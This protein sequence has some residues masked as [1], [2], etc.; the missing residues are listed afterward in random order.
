MNTNLAFTPIDDLR[1]QQEAAE[2]ARASLTHIHVGLNTTVRVTRDRPARERS[3][4]R[5]LAAYIHRERL[6][7]E[8]VCERL[9]ATVADVRAALT[10]SAADVK[11][12]VSRIESLRAILEANLR[13]PA[14]TAQCAA[15]IK[16]FKF[17]VKYGK[18]AEFVDLSR[19]GKTTIADWLH[20][21]HLDNAA[22]VDCP[23]EESYAAFIGSVARGCGITMSE[24]KKGRGPERILEQIEAMLGAGGLG[25]L[26]IDEGH[27][28][29]PTNIA[30]K[31]K[32]IEYDRKLWD[33]MKGR[34]SI[35]L[36]S[37]PQTILSSNQAQS[38]KNKRWNPA[39]WE[40]RV[41][42]FFP[43]EEVPEADVVKVA[44]WHCPEGSAAVIDPL[45]AFAR[46]TPGFYGAMVNV[47]DRA[48]FEAEI[49]GEKLGPKHVKVAMA[50]AIKGT[51]L[52]QVVKEGAR[53]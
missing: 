40:G 3:A 25:V 1:K 21:T 34:L 53:P 47:L 45:V 46:A 38:R 6:S 43:P 22:L 48:R 51:K 18:I 29:W 42:R 9:Q 35:C 28:L 44:R 49:D 26:I 39:Q 12:L 30:L 4:I 7:A 14:Q 16:S 41:N 17:A 52:G 31:P 5:W 15:A 36:F 27:Y 2:H 33:R 20:L 32:R 50:E 13:E 19:T 10:N 37:T 23:S 11:E 8:M 24:G